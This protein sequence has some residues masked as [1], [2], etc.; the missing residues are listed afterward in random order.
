MAAGLG[1]RST[2]SLL[3]VGVTLVGAVAGAVFG[4]DIVGG[5]TQYLLAR[6]NSALDKRNR[7]ESTR[8]GDTQGGHGHTGRWPGKWAGI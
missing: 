1:R 3:G 6:F 4:E 7:W 2:E 8:G 5:D